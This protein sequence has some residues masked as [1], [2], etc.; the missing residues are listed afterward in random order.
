MRNDAAG[1]LQEGEIYNGVYINHKDG[2]MTIATVS[3]KTITVKLNSVDGL[4]IFDGSTYKGGAAVVGGEVVNV[5]NIIT[6][7]INGDCYAT[8]GDYTVGSTVYKGIFV[9]N[10]AV[11]TTVPVGRFVFLG[12]SM[13][14]FDG[15]NINRIILG[16]SS[17]LGTNFRDRLNRGRIYFDDDSLSIYAPSGNTAIAT[18]NTSGVVWSPSTNNAIG[19]DAGGPFYIKNGSKV[20]F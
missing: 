10:K 4:A 15:N 3:G 7:N 11:S 16:T 13:Y 1:A 17:A 19:A 18:N 2:F 20:Y 6:N 8:I 12:S 9:F 5:S 14:I